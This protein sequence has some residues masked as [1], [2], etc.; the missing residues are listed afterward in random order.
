MAFEDVPY[1]TWL[2]EKLSEEKRRMESG[3]CNTYDDNFPS[4]SSGGRLYRSVSQVNSLI[5]IRFR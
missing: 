3:L 2:K 1:E 4:R 5:F